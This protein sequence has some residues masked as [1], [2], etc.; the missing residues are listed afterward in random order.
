MP[1][2]DK[3]GSDGYQRLMWALR[4]FADYTFRPVKVKKVS[5]NAVDTAGGVFSFQPGVACIVERL[6]LDV[7]TQSTGACTVD[8][9]I[10]ANA[11]TLNDTL[12]DGVSVAASG[13][14]DNIEDKGTNGKARQRCSA[15][16]FVTGSVASGAS[17]GLVGSAYIHY[18][19]TNP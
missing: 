17:A 7:T 4:T 15:T 13:L 5:L 8:A 19:E 18:I 1:G 9:G 14:K 16:Q 6:V 3:P 11:T 12:I 10:S 2:F